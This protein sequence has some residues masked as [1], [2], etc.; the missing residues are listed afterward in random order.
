MNSA[1]SSPS[2]S[3][4]SVATVRVGLLLCDDVDASAQLEYG[5]YAS[6]FARGLDAADGDFALAAYRCYQGEL[7]SSADAHDAYLISGSRCSVY[8]SLD[9]ILRLR[10]FVREC[11]ARRKKIV[12]ICFGHQLLAD[13][14]G[15]ATHK[16]ADGWGIGVHQT[17]IRESQPW[18]CA[19]ANDSPNDSSNDASNDAPNEYNLV[20]IHQDQVTALP[21]GFRA[22]AHNDFCPISMFVDADDNVLGIQGH[23][24]FDA[25]YCAYRLQS[26]KPQLSASAYQQSLESLERLTPDSAEVFDWVARF[27]RGAQCT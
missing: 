2:A 8:E 17:H 4:S 13:A 15:G 24:E 7:P 16:A 23:P 20:V 22:I 27:M 26:R 25:R 12:G 9:W 1:T 21:P 3:A 11:H 19:S 5:D 14:L 18:M 10:E 6:M